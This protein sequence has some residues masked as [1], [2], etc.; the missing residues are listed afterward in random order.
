MIS[1]PNRAT[2]FREAFAQKKWVMDGAM[3]T[4]L[5]SKGASSRKPVEELNLTLPAMVRDVHREYLAAG[6]EILRTNT[7]G[8]NRVRLA[9]ADLSA[10][11][12]DINRAA[13]R[14]A[15]TAAGEQAFIA[16]TIGP[17]GVRLAPLGSLTEQEARSVFH[18]QALA[19]TGVD[20]F[21]LETFRDLIE[22]RAAVDG[23]REAAGPDVV[24]AA[25]LTVEDDG[26]LQDGTQP[27]RYAQALNEVPADVVG[28]NCSRGPHAVFSALKWLPSTVHKPLSVA[29]GAGWPVPCS[30]DYF[31]RRFSTWNVHMAGGC[32]GTTPEHIRQLR[33]AVD[34]TEPQSSH[35]AFAVVSSWEYGDPPEKSNFGK[36]LDAGVYVTITES[37]ASDGVD[38]IGV[39]SRTEPTAL[40]AARLVEDPETILYVTARGR[41]A[42][43]LQRDLLA[44]HTLGERNILCLTGE[45]WGALDIDSIGLTH[46][47]ANLNRGLDFGG[48]PT[49][50]TAFTIG[51]AANPNA[52]DLD[53]E[54]ARFEAKVRAGAQFAIA[55]PV[56]DVTLFKTFLKRIDSFAIPVIASVWSIRDS[57]TADYTANE[58]HIPIP[59]SVMERI[60][61][62]EG[63][64]VARELAEAL[65][66]ISAGLRTLH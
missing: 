57:R 42:N 35:A 14:I 30:P 49:S 66:P 37:G 8:A 24:V 41:S 52:A 63:A 50:P 20:L 22:L 12:T 23:V 31:A 58:L 64:A 60:T 39:P 9:Q 51:V 5:F 6:A 62:G 13:V 29:P 2:E 65:R 45:G 48:N 15:R 53:R 18:H 25:H 17:T 61:A 7:F 47:A 3:A 10:K 34:S 33:A 36:K 55:Q 1:L 32:C 59:P 28:I 44:A 19:L 38:A 16:G 26:R 54:V 40:V 43:E 46:I 21:V 11:L 56:F 27:S 4:M